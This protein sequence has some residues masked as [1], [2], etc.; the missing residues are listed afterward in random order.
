[1]S[2]LRILGKLTYG[3]DAVRTIQTYFVH[4]TASSILTHYH[5]RQLISFIFI[6]KINIIIII[7]SIT[8]IIYKCTR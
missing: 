3:L 4:C 5:Y 6:I 1:M 7:I 8:N 2:N